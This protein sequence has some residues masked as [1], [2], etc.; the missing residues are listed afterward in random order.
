MVKQ[1]KV[2]WCRH[3]SL[4]HN[5][6]I[7]GAPNQVKIHRPSAWQI[8][9]ALTVNKTLLI[10]TLRSANSVTSIK[11]KSKKL[12]T[13]TNHV[14]GSQC[15]VAQTQTSWWNYWESGRNPKRKLRHSKI[16][17]WMFLTLKAH[18]RA[19]PNRNIGGVS[20]RCRQTISQRLK[21]TTLILTVAT[22][23]LRTIKGPCQ[24]FLR[25]EIWKYM[26]ECICG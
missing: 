22:C 11:Y 20:S 18:T 10:L 23:D 16:T 26:P 6:E 5:I 13:A 4:V 24:N 2:K 21:E 15:T 19:L 25:A 3:N 1:T 14:F 12:K 17:S 7:I 9:T 8:P